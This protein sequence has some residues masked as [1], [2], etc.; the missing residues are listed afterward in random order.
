MF[1][2][3]TLLRCG[4][5]VCASKIV[6]RYVRSGMCSRAFASLAPGGASDFRF[7]PLFFGAAVVVLLLFCVRALVYV[8]VKVIDSVLHCF[9]AGLLPTL[10]C[11]PTSRIVCF[12][13]HILVA[14]SFVAGNS[15]APNVV[16]G[17]RRPPSVKP[18][19][20]VRSAARPPR[21]VAVPVRHPDPI[22]EFRAAA[23]HPSVG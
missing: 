6:C 4:A 14:F 21:F 15:S 17:F 5:T 7:V 23:R 11:H 20:P 8:P 18:L 1:S 9:H 13:F 3:F 2:C 12:F 22:S 16:G 19:P 10:L